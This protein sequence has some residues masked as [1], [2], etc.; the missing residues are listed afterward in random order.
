MS[1]LA[2]TEEEEDVLVEDMS[3]ASEVIVFDDCWAGD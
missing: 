2:G 1:I 3:I